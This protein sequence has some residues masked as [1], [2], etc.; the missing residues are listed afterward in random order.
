VPEDI[1]WIPATSQG[2]SNSVLRRP[3]RRSRRTPCFRAQ[4]S[5]LPAIDDGGVSASQLKR[6]ENRKVELEEHPAH[7]EGLGGTGSFR[8]QSGEA[9][10]RI[11][12]VTLQAGSAAGLA[13][14]AFEARRG[15][16]CRAATISSQAAGNQ[17]RST[18]R[19]SRFSRLFL[20]RP[21]PASFGTAGRS[22][23]GPRRHFGCPSEMLVQVGQ[24]VTPGTNLAGSLTQRSSGEIKRC[25]TQAKDIPIGQSVEVDTRNGVISGS[26][27]HRPRRHQRH[28]NGRRQTGRRAAEGRGSG[29]ERRWDDRARGK[30]NDVSMSPAGLGQERATISLFKMS[31]MARRRSAQQ[32]SWDGCP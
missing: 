24:Q 22:V 16:A 18:G 9:D 32:S 12:R 11:Q 31:R 8:L 21:R 1:R 3:A 26:V 28:A 14:Q 30:M 2:A 15:R 23:E 17:H 7:S 19:S 27:M 10:Q 25:E 4:Q 20:I 29:F 13:A 6:Y 5:G